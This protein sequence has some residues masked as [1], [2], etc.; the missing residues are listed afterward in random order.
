MPEPTA[1]ICPLTMSTVPSGIG[2]S[3]G[4]SVDA[5]VLDDQRSGAEAQGWM[6]DAARPDGHKPDCDCG[7]HDCDSQKSDQ[8]KDPSSH[9]ELPLSTIRGRG[10]FGSMEVCESSIDRF[11]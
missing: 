3:S 9:L 5:G 8:A 10:W 6:G 4:A 7:N 1:A 2:G 11:H